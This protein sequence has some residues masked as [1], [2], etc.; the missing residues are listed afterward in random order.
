MNV[1][2]ETES[3][4]ELVARG[5]TATI[6]GMVSIGFHGLGIT[7]NVLSSLRLW[8]YPRLDILTD[9]DYNNLIPFKVQRLKCDQSRS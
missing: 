1:H 2:W 5:T 7:A 4:L 8:T 6:A 9:C 3:H